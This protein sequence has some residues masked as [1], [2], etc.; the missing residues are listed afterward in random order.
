MR[1]WM[2]V[3]IG[4]LAAVAV[5]FPADMSAVDYSLVLID[6]TTGSRREPARSDEPFA[7]TW[8]G[9]TEQP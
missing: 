4:V 6:A 3:L 2:T 7:P 5:C 9:R 8:L 1:P